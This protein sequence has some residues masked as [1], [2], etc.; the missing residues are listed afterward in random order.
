MSRGLRRLIGFGFAVAILVMPIFATTVEKMELPQ[1][2][3]ASDNIVQGHV[4]SVESR[5]EGR[6]IYTFVSVAVDD[7]IKGAKRSAVVLRQ[8]GGT[9]GFKTTWIAG[10]PQFKAGDQVVVFAHDRHDGTFDI[11]GLNQG[12]YDIVNDFAIARV[13]GVALVDSKTH[14][15]SEAGF[16][17]KVPVETLKARIRELVR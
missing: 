4:Q 3:T 2:V 8:L 5:Y 14:T 13:T 15:V 1:L 11:V 17:E 6:R 10:M 7:P 16:V 12:K 9:V